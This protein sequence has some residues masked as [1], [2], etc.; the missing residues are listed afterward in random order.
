MGNTVRNFDPTYIIKAD[1]FVEIDGSYYWKDDLT[2]ADPFLAQWQCKNPVEFSKK[3]ERRAKNGRFT[4]S[5]KKSFRRYQNRANRRND[6]VNIINALYS[7]VEENLLL[8]GNNPLPY[9]D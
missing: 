2:L 6:R 4:N 8:C 7:C 3:F 1:D 9:W 5:P